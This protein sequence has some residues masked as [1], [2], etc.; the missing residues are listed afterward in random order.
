MWFLEKQ[1][2]VVLGGN[3]Y[4]NVPNLVVY[5][6]QTLFTL[7]RHDGNGQLGIYFELYDATGQHIASVKRNEIYPTGR[8]GDLYKLDGSADECLLRRSD[9]N[10]Y[11][12]QIRKRR[13]SP[14]EL[15]VSVR[16]YTPD[17]FLFEAT[18]DATNLG[19]LTMSGNLV[20]RCEVGI[21]I[22]EQH[23]GVGL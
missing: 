23:I 15:E 17:G 7:R 16:L 12:C 13:T 22:A 1:F 14:I 6:D 9:T 10:E 19:D 2:R 3:A 21:N 20:V 18:P 11:V 8:Q 5:K 4:V